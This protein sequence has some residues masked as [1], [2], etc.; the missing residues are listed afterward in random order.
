MALTP[1][2]IPGEQYKLPLA[3]RKSS[4]TQVFFHGSSVNL[5]AGMT[6]SQNSLTDNFARQG[7]LVRLPRV[8]RFLFSSSG[9][10]PATAFTNHYSPLCSSLG[11]ALASHGICVAWGKDGG[12]SQ[13]WLSHATPDKDANFTAA[14]MVAGD[15]FTYVFASSNLAYGNDLIEYNSPLSAAATQYQ[16]DY[17]RFV[18]RHPRCK[19]FGGHIYQVPFGTDLDEIA[20]RAVSGAA[21]MAQ[22][23]QGLDQYGWTYTAVEWDLPAN[24]VGLS[25]IQAEVESFF[26]IA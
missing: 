22:F 24:Y 13:R 23:G 3:S 16:S 10:T 5:Y 15:I 4:Y 20:Q 11:M 6:G 12:A 18:E 21:P 14:N 17:N 1:F 19:S 8:V 2:S 25:A 26:G 9:G 7:Y